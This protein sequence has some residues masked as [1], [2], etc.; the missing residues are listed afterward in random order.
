LQETDRLFTCGYCRVKSYLVAKDCFRYVLPHPGSANKGLIYFPYWRFKGSL[1]FCRPAGIENRF[2][3]VSHQ[4]IVTPYFPFSI[5][6]RGQAMKLRFLTSAIEGR[7]LHPAWPFQKLLNTFEQRFGR[8]RPAGTNPILHQTHIGETLSL[9]YSPFYIDEDRL[10]DAVLDKPVSA[11]LPENFNLDDFHVGPADWRIHFVSTLCP[12][13]GWDLEGERDALVLICKNCKSTWH[14][15]GEKLQQVS[16]AQFRGKGDGLVYLP[17]WSIDA[18][19]ADLLLKS[20]ADLI[21]VANIPKTIRTGW[22]DIPLRFWIPAFKVR[23]QVF[24]RLAGHLTCSQP[25]QNLIAELPDGR[26]HP[27]TLPLG[28][29]LES[30]K[31]ILAGLLRSRQTLLARLQDIHITVKGF[32]LIYIPFHEAHHEFIQPDFQL[33]IQKN[34]LALAKNL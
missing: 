7:L 32:T 29:A 6:L 11:A 17:F 3:D 22:D 20:Y 24:L 28:E 10:Y 25:H 13:C 18:D 19:I 9:I 21:R 12:N 2:I 23:P 26:V 5:G 16:F 1:Y 4:A 8:C 14:A 15:I 34:V 33:S 30:L 27:S 31:L